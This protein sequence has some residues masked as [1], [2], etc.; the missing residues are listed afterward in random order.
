MEAVLP[1]NPHAPRFGGGGHPL[2]ELNGS[3]FVQ[4]GIATRGRIKALVRSQG[5]GII[6][7]S[8]G[9]AFFHKSSVDGR[10]W[11]L[12]VGDQVTFEWFDD[13]I[14]GARAYKVQPIRAPQQH[15]AT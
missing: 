6:R 5:S 11:D 8:R 7:A 12:N 15:R 13:P 4:T 1:G 10:Y 14:S 3:K 2:P 9:D